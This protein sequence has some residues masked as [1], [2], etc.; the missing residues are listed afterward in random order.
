MAYI[1]GQT[2]N[3]LINPY[4][5]ILNKY[6]SNTSN[7]YIDRTRTLDLLPIN[8]VCESDIAVKM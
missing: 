3:C 1:S 8:H 5:F 7:E 4:I 2:K 6:P